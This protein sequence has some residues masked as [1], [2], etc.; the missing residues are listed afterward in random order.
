MRWQQVYIVCLVAL[1]FS[2]AIGF[3]QDV[4]IANTSRYTSKPAKAVSQ[5]TINKQKK[6]FEILKTTLL[7]N[8][9]KP[10]L[11]NDSLTLVAKF[12]AVERQLD[13]Y[14]SDWEL[15]H[16][17]SSLVA[18]VKCGH[19][20][21]M[22]SKRLASIFYSYPTTLP[23]DV[24]LV[25]GKLY[26]LSTFRTKEKPRI[27]K[28]NEIVSINGVMMDEILQEMYKYFSSDGHNTTLKDRFFKDFFLFQYYLAFG[29][30]YNYD[31]E[32][33][34]KSGDTLSVTVP[35]EQPP[36]N[37]IARKAMK[38]PINQIPGSRDWGKLKISKSNDYALLKF[39]TFFYSEG[40]GYNEFLETTFTR[41][42]NSGVNNL[43]IDLRDNLGGKPQVQLMGYLS[44]TSVPIVSMEMND[45]KKPKYKRYIKKS[46]FYRRYRKE[47]RK[48]KNAI[49]KGDG[50]Y[51]IEG[52]SPSGFTENVFSGKIYVLTN[53]FTFSAGSNLAANLK[54][55]CGAV[56]IGE[57]TGG[58]HR[59]GNT[60]QLVLRLPKTKFEIMI[61]P[62][63]Y[64]NMTALNVGD[65][66][67]PP[68]IYTTDKY[69]QKR[70]EDPFMDEAL[71]LIKANKN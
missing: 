29:A 24:T 59:E 12:D 6:D 71:K 47:M 57:E 62:I 19:T 50:T 15:Y 23:G 13:E 64:S 66:G 27:S 36:F 42:K 4:A 49:V 65:A 37:S 55:K 22:P 33:V 3:A 60:G 30:T 39:E 61:N 21:M 11:Y 67:L 69:G 31:L 48:A 34:D 44:E 2:S 56:I 52:I 46:S 20:L 28:G 9:G 58:S 10:Y 54:E 5:K 14:R 26:A 17:F 7:E 43:I 51:K 38:N 45:A 18:D 16:M 41:I 1:I 35:A 40:V 68:D 8:T 70:S 32:F 63:Y 25:D 53:G